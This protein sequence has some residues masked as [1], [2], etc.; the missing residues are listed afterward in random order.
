MSGLILPNIAKK[1][2]L[3]KKQEEKKS[4]TFDIIVTGKTPIG[5]IVKVPTSKTKI[6]HLTKFEEL[7]DIR[8][9]VSKEIFETMLEIYENNQGYY[10]DKL[11]EGNVHISIIKQGLTKL[12]HWFAMILEPVDP[13]DIDDWLGRESHKI[14]K[15]ITIFCDEH[16]AKYCDPIPDK[17]VKFIRESH[18]GMI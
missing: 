14:E 13:E 11:E 10:Q 3:P 15:R 12:E 18:S 16:L 6:K 1:I 4:D 2:I 7:P 17:I 9:I 5:T 8:G